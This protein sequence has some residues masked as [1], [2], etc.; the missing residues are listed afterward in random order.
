MKTTGRD[1]AVVLALLCVSLLADET[2]ANTVHLKVYSSHLGHRR[3]RPQKALETVETAST[4]DWTGQGLASWGEAESNL[5]STVET[6]NV[7]SNALGAVVF[8]QTFEELQTLVCSNASLTQLNLNMTYLETL[9]ASGNWFT[10]FEDI[11]LATTI[12][13]LDLSENQLSDWK[14]FKLPR[15]LQ[16][17]NVSHNV[18]GDL[19]RSNLSAATDLV[20]I[21]LSSNNLTSVVGVI[22]PSNLTTLDLSNNS[23]ETFE[24]RETDLAVLSS[25]A[26][27]KMDDLEQLNCPISGATTETIGNVQVCVVSDTAFETAY[28]RSD[29]A[30]KMDKSLEYL[31]VILSAVI[32]LWFVVLLVGHSIK[33]RRHAAKT[34][35]QQRDTVEIS[36]LTAS[37]HWSLSKEEELPNDVRFDSEFTSFRIDPSDVMQVRTLAH[38]NFAMTSLVYLGDKQAVMKKVSVHSPGQDRDQMTAF[39]DEIRVCAKLEHPKVVGFLGIMWASL[40]DLSAIVEYV[41]RRSLAVYLKERKHSRKA[42]RLTFSWMESSNESPSKLSF[43]LQASEALVYLQSFAPPIIHGHVRAD[44][45]LLGSTWEVKLNRIGYRLDT[46]SLSIEDRAW[47]APEVLTSGA[48]DEKSDVYA[49]G[50]VMSELDR[51]KL[52]FSRKES[53]RQSVDGGTSLKPKFREDCPPEI[54]E[55]AQICLKDDPADRPT[56]MELHYSLRQFHRQSQDQ[57]GGSN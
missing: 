3:E 47:V 44:S 19:T 27:F 10:S 31:S 33:R 12:V 28:F 16:I 15:D 24:V 30:W 50:V 25:L 45:L 46:S 52:P 29:S 20:S 5:T 26:S 18:I 23:I 35:E 37:R 11:V 34:D 32:S 54:L 56:A 41:P 4:I 17:L 57:R 43:A 13:E 53:R 36:S 39:M 42:S 49:F 1:L 9:I 6:L 51:C 55:I 22:F 21:D 8:T 14:S 40:S 38:G 2:A 7:S 48:F